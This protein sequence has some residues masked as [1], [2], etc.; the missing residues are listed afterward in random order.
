MKVC[1]DACVFGAYISQKEKD[2][3][4]DETNI[5]DIGAGTGL[6]SLMMAQKVKGNID[7]IEIDEK[8]FAQAQENFR[9][10]PW[11]TRLSVFH[12]DVTGLHSEKNTILLFQIH[13]F[14]KTL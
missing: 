9:E 4:N 6:L 12:A 7:A 14:L 13:L 3:T 11:Q 1:T 5:A 10:S 2:Q 8:A